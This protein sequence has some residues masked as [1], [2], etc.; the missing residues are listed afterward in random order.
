MS[1]GTVT[2]QGNF[3]KIEC[4]PLPKILAALKAL[5]DRQFIYHD[6]SWTVPI[7]HRD[8]VERFAKRHNIQFGYVPAQESNDVYYISPL[9]ELTIDIPT[10]REMRPYQKPGVAYIMQKKR[11]I[12]GDDMGLGKTMQTVVS[13]AGFHQQGESVFPSLVICPSSVKLNWKREFELATYIKALVLAPQLLKTWP[14]YY[15]TG[16]AQV[17]IV[18]YESLKKYFVTSI[19]EMPKGKRPKISDITFNKNIELFKSVVID[20]VHRIKDSK[21]QQYK[22]TRGITAGKDIVLALT[23]TAVI[24]SPIDLASQLAVI[25]RLHEFGGYKYFEQHYCSGPRG[26]SN[27]AELNYHLNRICYYRRNKT[28]P[29]IKKYLP[30]KLRQVVICELSDH[31]RKEYIHAQKDLES[32]MR[33]VKLLSDE[34]VQKSM[35]GEVMVRI[36]ILKNISARGKLADAF[37]Y[38][39]D[40]IE[41]GQKIVVFCNLTEIIQAVQERFPK[42]VR[43]TGAE[44]D[45]RK[46]ENIDKFQTDPNC[47]VA[48]CNLKAAGV[49]VTL[50]ASQ[51]VCFIEFGWHAAIMDQAEDRCYRLGQHANV[52]CT[53]FLGKDTIDEWNYELIQTKRDIA[54]TVTGN[55]DDVEVNFIDKVMNLFS[56]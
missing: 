29:E 33:N 23:G 46:Q 16:L 26:A 24:N 45:R 11:L 17:F 12:I 53:Y 30:D 28:D 4:K 36:G 38:I 7:Q 20:E 5:P 1:L 52:M 19:K 48:A 42:S 44:D 8:E 35:K 13:L 31:A 37:D 27:L 6:K 2:Q 25:N 9:P 55:E 47:M 41:S 49:G 15:R 3:Y 54:N 56:V 34:Q 32:Y 10:R 39:R 50:T 43:I 18:N 14:E 40:V 21:T 51:Q 22:F